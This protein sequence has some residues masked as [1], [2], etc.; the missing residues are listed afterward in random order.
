MVAVVGAGGGVYAVTT[1]QA[2][3]TVPVPRKVQRVDPKPTHAQFLAKLNE[4]CYD[5]NIDPEYLRLE[6]EM[7]AT[8]EAGN[9]EGFHDALARHVRW[10]R[11]TIEKL[12]SIDAPA[13]DREAFGRYSR[14]ITTRQALNERMLPAVGRRD[15]AGVDDLRPLF[16]RANHQRIRAAIDLGAARCGQV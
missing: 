10:K 15:Q 2:T 8:W 12:V 5:G 14:A 1:T 9:W 3:D 13:Q 7:D 4:W 6:R 16:T 11:G